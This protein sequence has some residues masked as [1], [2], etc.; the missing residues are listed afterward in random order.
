MKLYPKRLVIIRVMTNEL[1]GSGEP[2]DMLL[3]VKTELLIFYRNISHGDITV[4][5]PESL[6]YYVKKYGVAQDFIVG[7]T[8]LA[9]RENLQIMLND[10]LHPYGHGYCLANSLL[11]EK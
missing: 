2:R 10:P 7:N 8:M 4:C 1:F 6:D 3:I 11:Y 9:T 5:M